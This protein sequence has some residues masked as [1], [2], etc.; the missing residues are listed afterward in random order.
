MYNECYKYAKI[1]RRKE[2]RNLYKHLYYFKLNLLPFCM[3]FF[4]Q[5]KLLKLEKIQERFLKIIFKNYTEN[6]EKL[7]QKSNDNTHL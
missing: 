6:Y 5:E 2:A 3:A 4:F 1:T 7:L